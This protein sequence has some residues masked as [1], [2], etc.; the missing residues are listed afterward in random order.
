MGG[1]EDFGE[2]ETDARGRTGDDEDLVLLSFLFW[3]DGREKG[4]DSLCR[5]GRGCLSRSRRELGGI[6]GRTSTF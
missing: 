4:G 3:V 6:I 2:F 1:V 5:L